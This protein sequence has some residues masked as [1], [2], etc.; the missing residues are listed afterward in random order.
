LLPIGAGLA[1][2]LTA[3]VALNRVLQSQ[4]VQVSPV[5]PLVAL[6]WE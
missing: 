3:A 4:L 6:R 1:A 2:G 5:D